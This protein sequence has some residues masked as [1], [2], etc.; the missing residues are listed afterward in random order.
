MQ[1]MISYISSDGGINKTILIYILLLSILT[2]SCRQRNEFAKG[3]YE[4][5]GDSVV[6]S[7]KGFSIARNGDYSVVTINNPWQG[8]EGISFKHF[9]VKRGSPLPQGTDSGQVIFVP[10]KSIICM[11]TTHIGMISA[12]GKQNSII[13]LSG[14]DLVYSTEVAERVSKGLVREV[15]FETSINQELII[16]L[17]PDLVMMYGIGNE[18]AGHV[19]KI[20]ELGIQIM[21][22]GDYL[23]TDPLGKAEW[24]K[25]FGALFCLE[26]IAD[27]L[28]RRESDEYN[29]IRNIVKNNIT[30]TYPLVMLGLPFKDTWF[31]SP[32]NSFV[33]KLIEDAGG[34]YLWK[35]TVS[36]YSIPYGLENVYIAA[37]SADC[38]LN[39]GTVKKKTEITMVD[40]RLADLKCFRNGNLYNN[41]KRINQMGG[42]D[43]W[44]SGALWPHLI[45]KDIASILNPDVFPGHE[46]YYYQKIN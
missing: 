37:I 45:L 7:A 23:E 22:N 17:S 26:D 8:A 21:F 42:N 30:V 13:G 29:K 46:L 25:L 10:L 11:S 36:E 28:F 9:L 5:S 41:N 34:N 43:Y 27:S 18:S 3:A 2:F 40:K 16:K 33:S 14:T 4:D 15:G 38:W 6:V 20:R 35:N 1:M 19:N 39:I 12:L 24:I 44:E 31:V 32:G